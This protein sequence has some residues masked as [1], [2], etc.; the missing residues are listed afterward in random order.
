VIAFSKLSRYRCNTEKRIVYSRSGRDLR[1]M[2][3]ELV[4]S[5]FV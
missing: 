2:Q 1:A 3:A 5:V 4:A